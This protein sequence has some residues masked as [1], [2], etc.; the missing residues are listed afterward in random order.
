MSEDPNSTRNRRFEILRE[1]LKAATGSDIPEIVNEIK[2]FLE[3]CVYYANE[4]PNYLAQL[5]PELLEVLHKI[6]PQFNEGAENTA[7][8]NI[9]EIVVKCPNLESIRNYYNQLFKIAEEVMNQDNEDNACIAIKLFIDLTRTFK[10]IVSEAYISKFIKYAEKMFKESADIC[11]RALDK[12]YQAG[13]L[14]ARNQSL[15]VLI[16]CGNGITSLYHHFQRLVNIK[17]FITYAFEIVCR[18]EP[19]NLNRNVKVYNDYILCKTK[20]LIFVA[21]FSRSERFY[22]EFKQYDDRLPQSIIKMMRTLP[23]DSYNIKKDLFQGFSEIIKSNHRKGFSRH[24]DSMLEDNEPNATANSIRSAW[25]GAMLEFLEIFKQEMTSEQLSK[26]TALICRNIHMF[27]L[28]VVQSLNVLKSFLDSIRALKDSQRVGRDRNLQI[29]DSMYQMILLTVSKRLGYCRGVIEENMPQ[30]KENRLN[31]TR[32]NQIVHEVCGILKRLSDLARSVINEKL[33]MPAAGSGQVS[34][35]QDYPTVRLITKIFKNL[36]ISSKIY[37]EMRADREEYNIYET[38][39]QLFS[40]FHPIALQD[41]LQALTPILFLKYVESAQIITKFFDSIKR[42]S[43]DSMRAMGDVL[44]PFVIDNLDILEPNSP[45]GEAKL[46]HL[47]WLAKTEMPPNIDKN[48]IRKRLWSFLELTLNYEVLEMHGKKLVQ[49]CED[50]CKT[51]TISKFVVLARNCITIVFKNKE[52]RYELSTPWIQQQD[53]LLLPF[54]P[55]HVIFQGLFSSSSEKITQACLLID[56]NLGRIQITPELLKR[57]Y[58]LL[59]KSHVSYNLEIMKILGKLGRSVRECRQAITF[60]SW[61]APLSPL[62]P[63]NSSVYTFHFSIYYDQNASALKIPL[64]YIILKIAKAFKAKTNVD[65][66]QKKTVLAASK[67]ISVA[68]LSLL[69]KFRIDHKLLAMK[70]AYVMSG[71]IEEIAQV[72]DGQPKLHK[73][74]FQE[75]L[76]NSIEALISLLAFSETSEEL[77]ELY[78]RVCI[79]FGM[80]IFISVEGEPV[81]IGMNPLDILEIL[82]EKLAYLEKGDERFLASLRGLTNILNTIGKLLHKDEAAL[83]RSESVKQVL[84]VLIRTCYKQEWTMQVGACGGLCRLF[85]KFPHQLI[86]AHATLILKT[87]LHILQSFPS[88]FKSQ[89]TDESVKLFNLASTHCSKETI[90]TELVSALLSR[91]PILRQIARQLIDDNNYVEDI[92]KI[93]NALSSNLC[94]YKPEISL[95][96]QLIDVIFLQNIKTAH[97]SVRTLILEAFTFC[98]KK[99]IIKISQDGNQVIYNFILTLVERA[100][101]FLEKEPKKDKTKDESPD[102][103]LNEKI[104]AYECMK[105]ILKNEE[106]WA[107]IRQK[108]EKYEKMRYKITFKFLRAMSQHNDQRVIDI[109]KEGIISLL[110]REENSRHILPQDELKACLRPI[111]LDLAKNS[112]LPSLPR[113]QNFSRL[114]E[115]ISNCFNT[116]LGDRLL[117]HLTDICSDHNARPLIPLVPAIANLFHLMPSCAVEILTPVITGFIKSEESLQKNSLQ[118]FLN[119]YF[120][121]PLIRYLSRFPNETLKFFF[122]DKFTEKRLLNYFIGLLGHPAG[123][124]LRECIAQRYQATLRDKFFSTGS[125]EFLSEGLKMLNCL[126]KYMPR[127]ISSK[128]DLI[129]ALYKVWKSMI[130]QEIQNEALIIEKGYIE[131]YMIKAFVSF[132]RYNHKDGIKQILFEI[133]LAFGRK[134]IWNTDFLSDFLQKELPS[135]LTLEEKYKTLKKLMQFLHDPQVHSQQKSK[136]LEFFTIPFLSETFKQENGKTILTKSL[137][138]S[139]IK[140]I[141]KH[142]NDISNTCCVQLMNLGSLF[143]ENLNQ[144][145]FPHRKELIKFCWGMIKSENP[146]IKGS[147]YVNVARFINIYN[148]PDT[149][150]VQLLGALLKAHHSELA[151]SSQQ[152]FTYL[153]EKLINLF[154]ESRLREYLTEF[155]RKNLLQETRQFQSMMHVIDIIIKNAHVFYYIREGLTSHFLNWINHLGLGLH[156]NYN[157]KKTLLDLTAVMIDWSDRHAKEIGDS[158][159]TAPHKEM[160]INFFARFGQ[161]PALYISR[162]PQRTFEQ[163]NFLSVRCI[164]NMKNALRLWGEVTF[165]AKNWT[166]ALKKCVNLVQ[167]HQQRGSSADALKKLLERS[168]NIVKILSEHNTRMAIV[169]Y[170]ELTKYLAL[171]VKITESPPLIKTL[172]DIIELLLNSRASD[173]KGQ[174]NEI[175]EASFADTSQQNYLWTVKL[176]AVVADFSPKDVT[177]HMKGLLQMTTTLVKELFQD[178]IGKENKFDAL[179][180]SLKIIQNNITLLADENKRALK[181]IIIIIF[182]GSTDPKIML[183]ACSLMEVWIT[184][185]PEDSQLTIKDQCSM[186]LK[187]FSSPK[188]EIQNASAPLQLSLRVLSAESSVYEPRIALCKAVLQYLLKDPSHEMKSAFNNLLKQMIGTSIW[189]RL[190]FAFEQQDC[191]ESKA[192]T[193]ASIDIILGALEESV[194]VEDDEMEEEAD[195][196]MDRDIAEFLRQHVWYITHKKVKYAKDLIAPLRQLLNL[197]ISHYLFTYL[198]PQLWE[199]FNKTQ[200]TALTYSIENLLTNRLAPEPVYHNSAKTI[201]TAVSSCYPLPII[202]PEIIHFLATAHNS[203][204][205]AIPLL[206][207]YTKYLP[208]SDKYI[209]LLENLYHRLSEREL[210]IGWKMI[211]AGNETTKLSLNTFLVADW[212]KARTEF[213]RI[214]G[215]GET[216]DVD[217]LEN[218][219]RESV[220]RLGDWTTLVEYGEPRQDLSLVES[221]WQSDEFGKMK[222][223][224][225]KLNISFHPTCIYYFCVADLAQSSDDNNSIRE[226]EKKNEFGT[227]GLLQ[228]WAAIPK[229]PSA[230]HIPIMQQLELKYEFYEGLVMLKAMEDH[231]SANKTPIDLVESINKWRRRK[232]SPQDGPRMWGSILKTRK[233]F[234]KHMGIIAQKNPNYISASEIGNLQDSTWTDVTHAK[235]CRKAGIYSKAASILENLTNEES[236]SEMFLIAKEKIKLCMSTEYYEGAL[237]LARFYSQENTNIDPTKISEFKRLKG[238]IYSRINDE[239]K[240]KNCFSNAA[241]TSPKI[242]KNWLSWA[243]LISKDYEENRSP[244]MATQ[245]MVAYLLGI[246]SNLQKYRLYIPKILLLL[247][248]CDSPSSFEEFSDRISLSLMAN[249]IPQLLSSLGRPNSDAIYKLLIKI[250]TQKPQSLFYHLRSLI[251]EINDQYASSPTEVLNE[252]LRYPQ[253]LMG[254]LRK[255]HPILIQTLEILC[256]NLSQNLKVSIE[257]DFYNTISNLLQLTFITNEEITEEH[258]QETFESIDDKFFNRDDNVEFIEKYHED[259]M[260]DFNENIYG[261]LRQIQL[262]LKKWKD[263]LSQEI[264]LNDLK[265]L[266]QECIDLSTFYSKEIEIPGTE[267][268]ILERFLPKI[269]PIRGKNSNRAL[270]IR[271]SNGKDY[272]F[273]VA[274]NAPFSHSSYRLTQIMK[275]LNHCFIVHGH[276]IS[277]RIQG[278]NFDIQEQVPIDSRHSLVEMRS[279]SISLNEIYNLTVDET[280]NDPDFWIFEDN[281]E[282][283][284][285]HLFSSYIQRCL[286]SPDRFA[287]FSKQFTA[288]WGLFYVLAELLEIPINQQLLTRLWISKTSGTLELGFSDL[289]LISNYEG[290]IGV[291]LT[292]NIK[293]LIG[294][295][296]I[297]GLMP[298]VISNSMKLILK[299]KSQIEPLLYYILRDE[300]EADMTKI[301]SI[302]EE[303]IDVQNIHQK[304]EMSIQEPISASSLKWF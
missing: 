233:V 56:E 257:E 199:S 281:D 61:S 231:L 263:R 46:F 141:R 206:Q 121:V 194:V 190:Q 235:L 73:I 174:L 249:W 236:Q 217:I 126:V 44:M 298:A 72:V 57:L 222:S 300:G 19:E 282:I 116:N 88:N 224:C 38:I 292:P 99:G 151:Q 270:T 293:Y 290:T 212:D 202:R 294:E 161:A 48:A 268:V 271:G 156:S 112:N 178:T 26:A 278:S 108:D 123:Y 47:Y 20:I 77:G 264:K 132:I 138:V 223:L 136:V 272:T 58:E 168:L 154:K 143:I 207:A 248:N 2:D 82:C 303:N 226:L 302:I 262:N 113:L 267:K 110:E 45:M 65:E 179:L 211:R 55:S 186:L 118:G 35:L 238:I 96:Q 76:R 10:D 79:H 15:K 169:Q 243:H 195:W 239:E 146:F 277:H 114:L 117:H 240:S 75:T 144:E 53:P 71:K 171:Q 131:K 246:Q 242:M 122:E 29:V 133:P 106:M 165:K 184:Q 260:N 69:S 5:I 164:N 301:M 250:A 197:P 196:G 89:I 181:N 33:Y 21:Q 216:E 296:G 87:S 22:E 205:I 163:M 101:D 261:N 220:E 95:Q 145:F 78:E 241:A 92:G 90:V 70:V 291:R 229:Y 93:H 152:A 187:L 259:F 97:V 192:W 285:E 279:G 149:L 34:I 63:G 175:L 17:D 8:Q 129:D 37:S 193:K 49:K 86:Q 172:C 103:V 230:A 39:S 105:T 36:I 297:K 245:A 11:T 228:E 283:V 185:C 115:V 125:P 304:L 266:D 275:N 189:R 167:Q 7:R 28:L 62:S 210:E 135:I 107:F 31:N 66:N 244:E 52:L 188:L 128:Q 219:W 85:S 177:N 274:V 153:S 221:Y 109:V 23:S 247:E 215:S 201:L 155:V 139:T 158:Y 24:I 140:L 51:E 27:P 148:L 124:P 251:L 18:D 91:S 213:E 183:E 287:V 104:A 295:A 269:V 98:L 182:E 209:Y 43:R 253:L 150:T 200:Q 64:D 254:E 162:T 14:L 147:A 288:Q 3:R 119:S 157:A 84:L 180:T 120:T 137:Q 127:W 41:I 42:S 237:N 83:S 166:E 252:K 40:S 176:L 204:N 232:I 130:D 134:Q 12:K 81:E 54:P 214:L 289:P 286:Q 208:E 25:Y 59:H 111:L 276:K 255:K 94:P 284:P 225:H 280:G 80:L 60:K 170:P 6:P 30:I 234:F 1:K 142:L 273:M 299:Q 258:V 67:L 68:I 191:S 13:S 74:A 9:L 32:T 160:L 50:L 102:L 218:S 227:M 173:L 203:W 159:I 198:F 16:E 256:Q 265:Y 100:D 4:Q